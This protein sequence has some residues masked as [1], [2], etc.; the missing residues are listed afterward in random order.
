MYGIHVKQKNAFRIQIIIYQF[1]H[2]TQF[3]SVRNIV[4]TV[5]DTYHSPHRTIQFKFLHILQK[6]QNILSG[7]YSFFHCFCKHFLRIIHTNHIITLASKQSC[8]CPGSTSKF[9]NQTICNLIFSET[10]CNILRPSFII[11]V[12]HEQIIDLCKLLIC[13]HSFS[14]LSVILYLFLPN[15]CSVQKGR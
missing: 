11:N 9:Q 8:H 13:T 7:F 10:I 14:P 12:I 5:T 4:Q 3:I 1:K 15:S 2:M 6:I